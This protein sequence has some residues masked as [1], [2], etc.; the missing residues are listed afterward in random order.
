MEEG[1]IEL[2]TEAAVFGGL[3]VQG[4]KGK[5]GFTVKAEFMRRER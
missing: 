4:S 3:D 1:T 5:F 2:P